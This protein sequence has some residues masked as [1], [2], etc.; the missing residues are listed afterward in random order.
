MALNR[1]TA[2]PF[3]VADPP[4]ARLLFS[5][6]RMAWFWL[7]VRLYVG[8]AWVDCRWTVS[9]WPMSEGGWLHRLSAADVADAAMDSTEGAACAFPMPPRWAGRS[10]RRSQ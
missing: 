3:R 5:D 9:S 7:V 2:S 6:T 10:A 1:L 8:Y 4:L